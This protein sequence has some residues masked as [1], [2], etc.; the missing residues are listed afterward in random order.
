[1]Q[2]AYQMKTKNRITLQQS[3]IPDY[4]IGF[5]KLLRKSLGDSFQIFAGKGDFGGSPVSSTE[6]W[7]HFSCVKNIYLGGGRILWQK[8]SFRRLL[9]SD[10]CLLNANLRNFSNNIILVLR[11]LLGRRTVLWGHAEGKSYVASK[12]RGT[13]LRFC[14][15]F[16]AYTKNQGD[17]M[18][19]RYPWLKIWIA[20]NSCMHASDCRPAGKSLDEVDSLLYVG[21]L[22]EKKKVTL[23]LDSFNYLCS[24]NLIPKTRLVFVGEGTEREKLIAKAKL[25]GLEDR[26]DFLGHVADISELRQIYS[27]AICAIS[28]G[29]VGLSV[30]QAFSFGVPMLVAR[31]EFHSPEIEACREGFNMQYFESDNLHALA[32]VMVEMVN[33]KM[34]WHSKRIELSE[35]TASNYS[36]ELMRDAFLNAIMNEKVTRMI[37]RIAGKLIRATLPELKYKLPLKLN[38]NYRRIYHLHV[39]K[40]AGTSLNHIF[41]NL[42]GE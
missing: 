4:R 25:A 23:L 36:F 16:I 38:C 13:Y 40:T 7:K 19:V 20:P 37:K 27:K 28:P 41:M 33:Q 26:I 8:G 35:W 15:G 39:R 14:D 21:R 22:V 10:I 6:A 17:Y 42:S 2:I 5:F 32:K 12:L 3:I 18:K 34:F 30:T 29:Y 31:E 9:S 24:K 1:M 11:K